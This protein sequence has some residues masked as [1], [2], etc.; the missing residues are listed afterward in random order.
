MFIIIKGYRQGH[1]RIVN[2]TLADSGVYECVAKTP[3]ASISIS[4]TLN[5]LGPPGPPGK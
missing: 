2:V 5:V 4:T 3:V 1:L